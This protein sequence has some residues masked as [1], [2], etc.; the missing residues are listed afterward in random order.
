M[1]TEIMYKAAQKAV[2]RENF[3]KEDMD[4]FATRHNLSGGDVLKLIVDAQK[5]HCMF[6]FLGCNDTQG[7]HIA[8]DMET[9]ESVIG[10]KHLTCEEIC[11]HGCC[12]F[13][14]KILYRTEEKMLE[15]ENNEAEE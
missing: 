1:V 11:Q 6:N 10:H 12:A 15:I 2:C 14:N 4:D 5:E 13:I 8:F 3:A 9:L 7:E